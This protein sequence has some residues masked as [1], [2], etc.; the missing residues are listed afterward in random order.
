MRMMDSLSIRVSMTIFVFSIGGAGVVV[1][2]TA[3]TVGHVPSLVSFRTGH[4]SLVVLDVDGVVDV[5]LVA[6]V[7]AIFVVAFWVVAGGSC[8]AEV[9]VGS[10]H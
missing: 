2:H 4:R 8:V 9:V 7:V 6:G 3:L 1:F 5:V 10:S